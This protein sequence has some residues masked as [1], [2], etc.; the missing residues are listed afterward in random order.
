MALL[1]EVLVPMYFFHRYQTEATAKAI[2]GLN[3][4]YALRGD[5]QPV[6]EMVAPQQQIKAIEALLKTVDPTVLAIPESILKLI[7]PRPLGYS[8][9][10]EVINIRTELTFDPLAAAEEAANLSF[11]LLFHPTRAARLVEYHARDARLPSLE[12][13]IDKAI[14]HTFKSSAKPGYEGAVQ[15][16]VN[17]SL[18][19]NLMVLAGH[20]DASHQV[21][22][23]ANLELDKLSTWLNGK[24]KTTSDEDWKAHYIYTLSQIE[25]Y[26][27][28]PAEFKIE[29]LL[30]APPGQPIGD[31]G[32]DYCGN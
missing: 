29:I 22:A 24:V 12:N 15:I 6:T 9:H 5:G 2:G 18:L 20:K 32:L 21:R 28:D 25:R 1:E 13:V 11:S 19:I 31:Y 26:K 23:I 17:N 30:D 27:E 3:Y 16:T 8:R 14:G 4:R 7:P 10:R